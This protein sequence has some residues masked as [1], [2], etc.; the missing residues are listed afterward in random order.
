MKNISIILIRM[1]SGFFLC[2]CSTVIAIN[3]NLGLSP[4]DVFHQ[5]L[6]NIVNITIGQASIFVGILIVIVASI[7][8]LKV[9]LGTLANMTIIGCFIDLII[10]L[11]IIPTSINLFTGVL[12]MIG[13]MFVNALGSYLYIG[14]EMGCGPRDGLMVALVK[15]TSKPIS[16]IRFFIEGSALAIGWLLGGTVGIGTLVTV[17][18]VGYCVQFT[19][20]SF[21]F[22]VKNLNHKNLKQCFLFINKCIS[23]EESKDEI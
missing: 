1:L 3:S 2:A 20:K 19:Y 14:C 11:D 22:D 12:L 4:W 6:A 15:L 13:S 16:L 21:K 10:Y 18:G 9:G 23:K 5:G 17:I 7:L 8:G